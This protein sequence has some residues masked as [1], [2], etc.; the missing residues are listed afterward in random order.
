MGDTLRM[1]QPGP[2]PAGTGRGDGWTSARVAVLVAVGVLAL[3][4]GV[5]GGFLIGDSSGNGGTTVISNA[6]KENHTVTVTQPP[7]TVTIIQS[8]TETRTVTE[9]GPAT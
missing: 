6:T 2:P 4:V 8:I 5:L 1:P 9:T 3:A 7:S